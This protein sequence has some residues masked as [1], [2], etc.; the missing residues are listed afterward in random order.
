[1]LNRHITP[2]ILDKLSMFPEEI[3]LTILIIFLFFD[4]A[5]IAIIVHYACKLCSNIA[6]CFA[7]D[8]KITLE[9]EN[10]GRIIGELQKTR[11]EI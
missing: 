4:F 2:E 7:R 6:S 10:S 8:I 5:I 9:E 1:M 11:H 3:R